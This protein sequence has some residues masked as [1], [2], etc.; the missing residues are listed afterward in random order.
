MS[1]REYS[2]VSHRFWTGPT[3]RALR[4]KG[5][6][7]QLV[8]LY[9]LT[10]ESANMIGFYPLPLA[11]GAAHTGLSPEEFAAA[12]HACEEV[13]FCRY[14]YD[15]EVVWVVKMA[16]YQMGRRGGKAASPLSI[17]GAEKQAYAVDY[18]DLSNEF[19][20]VYGDM[21]GTPKFP[22]DERPP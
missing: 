1:T 16:F 22:S 9:L 3:G 6:H 13:G 11:T 14:D 10:A 21:T 5:A 2:Q 7:A 18:S 17:K 15:N 20:E 8:A 19:Y 4:R 12:I